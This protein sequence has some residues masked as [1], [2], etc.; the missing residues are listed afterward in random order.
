MRGVYELDDFVYSWSFGDNTSSSEKLP[1][2]QYATPGNFTVNLTVTAEN[3]CTDSKTGIAT[4]RELPTAAIILN[5]STELCDTDSAILIASTNA[6]TY[7]WSNGLGGDTLVAKQEEEYIL[8]AT[9]QFGCVNRANIFIEE[10]DAPVVVEHRDTALVKGNSIELS[11]IGNAASYSW[12]PSSS[13]N[14]ASGETVIASPTESTTYRVTGTS[15]KG[16][17]T[18][19]EVYVRVD[20]D[21]TIDYT[22]VITPNG[23]G[24]NDKFRIR[25]IH[26]F[27]FCPL[28]IYNRYGDM[29]FSR[30]DYRNDWE[31]TFDGGQLPE[32]TY[33]FTIDC[34]DVENNQFTGA[35]TIIR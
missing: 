2:H 19:K 17:T 35:I 34:S 9:D 23:D 11:V 6:P 12:S 7:F 13:L 16:C 22:N 28:R 32:D 15:S 29:V 4:V 21:Y 18:T 30:Q 5:G 20:D 8:I 27:Q 25:N 24:V 1:T 26:R 14:R 10:L 3:G 33:Y 31:G